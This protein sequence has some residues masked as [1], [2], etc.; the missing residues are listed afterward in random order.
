MQS[1]IVI[2]FLILII[3]PGLILA[4]RIQPTFQKNI[5]NTT[6][7]TL[8]KKLLP[9]DVDRDGLIDIVAVAS[10]T[11][12]AP[13]VV[14]Y[15]NDGASGFTEHILSTNFTTARCVYAADFNKGGYLEIIAGTQDSKL[16]NLWEYNTGTEQWNSSS[17]GQGQASYNYSIRGRDINDD[18][19]VDILTTYGP[20]QNRISWFEND[21]TGGFSEV[22]IVDVYAL[23]VDAEAGKI[24]NDSD[25]DIVGAKFYT[26]ELEENVSWF[27]NDGTPEDPYWN[28]TFVDD[29]SSDC[30][31]IL[32]CDKIL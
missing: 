29:N 7:L 25:I 3:M 18:G 14:W 26:E 15:Q 13:N 11:T 2:I 23:S 21:G 12:T 27:E 31:S 6:T 24:D 19:E 9:A 32:L 30:K 10:N 4:Q 16:I 28:Q 22:V 17:I 1:K 20:I 8:A 5:V